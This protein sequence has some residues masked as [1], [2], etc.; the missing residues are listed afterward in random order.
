[1]K[2]D[3]MIA[4]DADRLMSLEEVAARLRTSPKVVS[5]LLDTGLLKGLKFRSNR[6]VRKV[7]FNNFLDQYDG[8]DIYDILEQN[9]K[10]RTEA[11]S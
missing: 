9:E 5:D 8:C 11:S 2:T 3:V 1:M 4:D 7:T 6:R 10:H